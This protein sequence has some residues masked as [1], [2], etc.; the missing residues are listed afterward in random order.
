[1]RAESLNI[2]KS[3]VLRILKEEF[4]KRKLYARFVPHS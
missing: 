3:L 2:P 4:G 1:M